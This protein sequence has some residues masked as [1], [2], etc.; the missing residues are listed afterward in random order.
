MILEAHYLFSLDLAPFSKYSKTF[1]KRPLMGNSE[2][3]G[4]N[5]T[6]YCELLSVLNKVR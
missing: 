6:K 1:V 4:I 3:E 5:F 2:G